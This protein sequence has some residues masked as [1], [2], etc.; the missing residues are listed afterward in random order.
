[1]STPGAAPRRIVPETVQTSGMDCGPAALHSLLAGFGIPVSY[2][3]LREACQTDVDGTSIDAL[4]SVARTLGLDVA[5]LMLPADHV[6][7][8]C[9]TAMPAIA[10]A[11]LPSGMPHFVVAWRRHGRLVQ[12]MDPGTGRRIVAA[13][14]LEQMLY[15]H[16][17]PVPFAAWEAFATAPTFRDALRERLGALG[18]RSRDAEQLVARAAA[19]GGRALAALDAQARAL[20]TPPSERAA[21]AAVLEEGLATAPGGRAARAAVLK[22]ALAPAAREPAGRALALERAVDDPGGAL[23]GLPAEAWFARPLTADAEPDEV[24]LRGAVLVRARD[25]AD[26]PPDPATLPPDLAAALTEPPPRPAQRLL[27]VARD[28]GRVAIAPLALAIALLAGGAVAEAALLRG[29]LDAIDVRRTLLVVAGIALLLAAV[30]T[31]TAAGA[32]GIGRR[33]EV[34]LRRA[35]ALALPRL[36]DRYLRSRPP[37]DMAERAHALHE[38]RMLPLLATQLLAAALETLF[39]AIALCVL[40]PASTPYVALATGGA[41]G[42]ALVVQLPLRERELRAREHA[43]ALGQTTLDGVLGVL[44]IRAHGAQRALSSE[45]DVRLRGWIGA[46][47]AAVRARGAAAFAQ[48]ACGIGLAI[49]VV[50]IGLDHLDSPPERLLLVLWAV[51]IPVAAERVG[52]IALQWPQLRTL[53]VRLAAPLDAPLAADVSLAPGAAS[54]PAEVVFDGVTVRATGQDV[55]APT[56]L[57]VAA[58]EHVAL[59]GLSGAGKSTL[60]ALALGLADPSGGR[61]VVGGGDPR[62]MWPAVAWVDPQVR[63]WNRDLAH[64]VAPL[65]SEERVR[66]LLA[67]AE[68]AAV[69]ARVDGD[70]L[71]SDGG[72]LSGGEA[73]RVR[74]ARAL[75]REGVRLAVLDEP[76][77]GLDREQR[78]R[79]LAAARERW[80]DATLLCATHDV[81]EALA[82]DRVLVME[83]GR[84]VAD[85]S[86]EEL[87]AEAGSPLRAMLDTERALRDELDRGPGWRRLRVVDGTL[88]EKPRAWSSAAAPAA[89]AATAPGESSAAAQEPSAAV[90]SAGA[91]TPA[92]VPASITAPAPESTSASAPE[93]IAGEPVRPGGAVPALAVFGSATILRYATF[94]ASWSV[95]GSAIFSG[96]G[97]GDA[98]TTWA[99]LLAASVPLATIAEL[100]EGRA[101]IAL[102]ARLRERTLRGALALD[103]SWVRREGPGRILGRAMEVDA[104]ARLAAGGGLS[105]GTAAIELSVGAVALLA[106]APGRAAALPLAAVLVAA[107]LVAASALRRRRAWSAARLSET[108]ELL[109]AIAGQRTRLIQGD[110]EAGRRARKLDEYARL[111]AAADRPIALLAGALPRAALAAG[112]AGLALSG[113]LSN[114]SDVALALGGVLLSAQA[115][116]LIA[117]AVETLGSAAIARQALEPI[118]AAATADPAGQ[119]GMPRG[120]DGPP[121]QAAAPSVLQVRGLGVDRGGREVLREVDLD[122]RPG[123]AAVLSGPS[124]AGKST[125]AAALAGLLPAAHGTVALGGARP[126]DPGWRTRV[127]FVPQHGDN[128]VLLAPMAFNLLMGRHWPPRAQD[129]ADADAICQELGLGPLLR[130]M[131]AGIGQVV[132]ETGW[133]LSQ[134]ERARLCLARALLADH[135]VLILDEPLG[136]LDPHTARTILDV[137]RRRARTL[138]VVS[139][140]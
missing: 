24:M 115:L 32:M 139:Q 70:A 111:G 6:V 101:A 2:G 117:A 53:A 16:E 3:R 86:P 50:V 131:P 58:G 8:R 69:A 47:R 121:A 26:E 125:L 98:L 116:R 94:A 122:L 109:E 127:G 37:S 49:P 78:R 61:V 140:E 71:G 134:G 74:L 135:D 19:A 60:L 112:L 97:R 105:A 39:V 66:A 29:S 96:G 54:G 11:L 106:S 44:A 128:H 83:G 20:A 27:A 48:T 51:T 9:A 91:P 72:L 123:D 102:G 95:I 42:V 36:P 15:I 31:M 103:A 120:A 59:V 92:A 80:R 33:L 12:V 110:H 118:L 64:N 14:T 13:R 87:L 5:Q 7:L 57:R 21:G 85:G 43:S 56:T 99:V 28:A 46:A 104:I 119:A 10:V 35:L 1:V 138:V 18:L 137:V 52:Q 55:L 81:G 38:L 65:A 114:P 133:R 126:Q 100:A 93:G 90:P 130:R 124:G 75:D 4:E 76:L 79:L 34:G 30:E 22:R 89:T 23:A 41:L 45:H 63:V 73:Q 77:R 88:S 129:L 17:Q 132:G 40:D 67:E 113:D 136:A 25:L 84:V 68:L 107:G 108:D 82:F 62:A